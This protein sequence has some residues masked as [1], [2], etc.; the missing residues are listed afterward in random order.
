GWLGGLGFA[1]AALTVRDRD[2]WI[3]WDAETR[4]AHQ[5]KFVSMSRFLIR[6]DIHCQNLASR[7][8][9]LA[10]RR[11]P[12]DFE[13]KY[14][15]RPWVLET[16][17][18]TSRFSGTCYRA[19][20]W[21]RVG[22]TQGR[23]RQDQHNQAGKSV[24]DIYVYPLVSDFR[25]RMGLP[26]HAGQGPLPVDQG[27][28][29]GQWAE[30]E[31]GSAPLGDQR[32][33]KR[34]VRVAQAKAQHPQLS[35]PQVLQADTAALKGYY[36]LID[37]SDTDAVNMATMLQAHRAC[38]MRRMQAY[39]QVLAIHDE[40][41]LDYASLGE[42]E[43]RGVIGKNQT[44]TESKGL[45][46]HSTFV[47]TPD[48]G[49]PLGLLRV[50]CVAPELKPHHKGKDK[51]YIPI[52]DKDTLRWVDSL[53]DSVEVAHGMPGTT[54]INVMDREGDFFELFDAWRCDPRGH[55]LV[56]A[57]HDRRIDGDATLFESVKRSPI[58][59]RLVV[60]LCRRSARPKKGRRAALPA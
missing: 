25:E 17:V 32:L 36:R 47:V 39:R 2:D 33:S 55:V 54:V 16:F 3:G 41:D 56:R 22:Q 13:H 52:E 40:T 9:G 53:R 51:R 60:P 12:P 44:G 30:Q 59:A 34:L 8:L 29:G 19:A 20:N 50:E 10:L 14:G 1:A 31:F 4:R 21:R 37:H 26:A 58:Q 24:K 7:V 46:L 28:N 6:N 38:T 23:G 42:C 57:K 48:T 27:L 18:D 45:S 43:G 11:L 15:Y 35:M 49:L 5:D